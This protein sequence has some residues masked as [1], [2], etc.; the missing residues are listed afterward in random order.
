MNKLVVFE[1]DL[2]KL[3]TICRRCQMC[4][5]AKVTQRMGT[6]VSILQE[7]GCGYGYRW[8]SQPFVGDI[9]TG[10]LL[11]SASILFSGSQPTNVLRLLSH[12]NLQCYSVNT[13]FTH[14]RHF[15]LPAVESVLNSSAGL[16]CQFAKE[17]GGDVC[18]A[19]DGRSD[20]PGHSAKYGSY[21]VMYLEACNVLDIK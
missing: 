4:K 11:L 9:P 15:M 10:N 8:S 19:G 6:F 16:L 14:Q 12:M 2:L 5:T 20:S 17:R 1:D 21:T 18:L 13:F 3:F 7:C